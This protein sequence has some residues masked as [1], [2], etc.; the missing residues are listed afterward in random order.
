MGC[1]FCQGVYLKKK[2]P[3]VA[4][5]AFFAESGLTGRMAIVGDG[6]LLDELTHLA[7]ALG[8]T[9]RIDF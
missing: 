5:K 4:I 6:P 8:L 1:N 2:Q 3:D 9:K 7:E